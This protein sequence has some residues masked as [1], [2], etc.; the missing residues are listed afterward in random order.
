LSTDAALVAVDARGNP[1]LVGEALA[2]I[3]AGGTGHGA[4]RRQD[5]VEVEL[6]AQ[7]PFGHRY[8]ILGR[9]RR[10]PRQAER[11]LDLDSLAGDIL[12]GVRIDGLFAGIVPEGG[13]AVPFLRILTAIH[14]EDG[15]V[16]LE[17]DFHPFV[18]DLPVE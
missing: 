1:G 11:Y 2:R 14:E 5:G 7:G 15:A 4:V 13:Q 17:R 9:H 8:G 12:T 18:G 3:V 10:I 16:V 6:L